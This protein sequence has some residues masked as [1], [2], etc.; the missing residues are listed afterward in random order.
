MPKNPKKINSENNFKIEGFFGNMIKDSKKQENIKKSEDTKL[1]KNIIENPYKEKNSKNKKEKVKVIP[2]E[3]KEEK[4]QRS[5]P[6][7][8]SIKNDIIKKDEELKEN[9]KGKEKEKNNININLNNKNNKKKKLIKKKIISDSDSSYNASKELNDDKEDLN[10]SDYKMDIMEIEEEERDHFNKSK[11]KSKSKSN[12]RKN[13]NTK[14]KEEKIFDEDIDFEKLKFNMDE[15]E[16]REKKEKEKE[17]KDK[18]KSSSNKSNKK[19]GNNSAIKSTRNKSRDKSSSIKK[20]S[21]TSSSNNSNIN[22]IEGPLSEETIVI[23]GE[24]DIKR[25]DLTN[26]LKSLGARVTGSVSSRTTILLHGDVLEDGR[27]VTEGRK[28]RQAKEKN[29]T[30]MDRYQFEQH[31]QKITKNPKW[32]LSD[33]KIESDIEIKE[34]P[35]NEEESSKNNKNKKNKSKNSIQN[36]GELWTTKYSPK[37]ISELIGNKT[38]INKLITWL[39]DWNSVVL[40]GNKKKIETKFIRGQ[41]PTFENLNARACLITGDPGIGK[42]SSVRLIAKLKGYKT[43][44]TNASDQRNKNSINKNAGFIYDNKTLFGGE[45]QEK[46]LIIMDEVDGMSGNEDRGGISAIIDIIKKTKIPIICIA[47]DRQSPKLKTLANYCYDL[48]FIHPDKRTI[49][50][51]IAEICKNENINYEMN[52]LEYLCEICGNDI[53]QIINFVELW[54]RQNKSIK[55]KDL[56]GGNQKLQGKDEVVMLTNFDAAK[57]LLNS[58]SRSKSFRDLLDLYFIDYDLIPLL[59]QENY[60]STFPSQNFKSSYEELDNVSLA[61]DLISYSDVMDKKIRTQMD[62]RLLADRGLIGC[63]TLCK[64][65]KGFV[66][67]PKFPEAMGKI[68]SLNKIKREVTEL[69]E[70]FPSYSANEIRRDILP[71]MYTYLIDTIIEGDIEATLDLMKKYRIT[72]EYFKENMTDLVG[73][74]LKIQFEKLGTSNKSNLTRAYNKNFKSSIIRT[75]NKKGKGKSSVNVNNSQNIYDENGNPLNEIMEEE[76]EDNDESSDSV[77]DIKG[78]TK[79]KGKSRSKSNSNDD[80]KGSKSKTKGKSKSKS[81]SKVKNGKNKGKKK[82]KKKKDESEEDEYD[83]EDDED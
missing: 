27:P 22:I 36:Q 67:F 68:S 70:C 53:R 25:D 5:K 69:K 9:N 51:R 71:V 11:S 59:I 50:I 54:S 77:L 6:K 61:A 7:K 38:T 43:Y 66:P 15:E 79:T 12:S 64:I 19:S 58:K 41:R 21:R 46:N 76:D 28:Y 3:K 32:S 45:L 16:K 52:A 13:I 60:L 14:K 47:N 48:K 20:K 1:S 2:E 65:N 29:I 63:C 40:E 31:V 80:K 35:S 39:D 23:T 73:E 62:W 72:M 55:F 44:E 10:F 81:K 26:I 57:E 75:K 78:K 74:K 49:A 82:A 33:T 30:I 18:S 56:T 17:K 42:T 37:K 83:F 4:R 24:F 34:E 8:I